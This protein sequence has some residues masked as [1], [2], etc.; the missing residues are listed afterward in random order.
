MVHLRF[1]PVARLMAVFVTVAAL[2]V[3]CGSDVSGK[4]LAQGEGSRTE[5]STP[6]APS[7]QGA[8]SGGDTSA[9]SP[10]EI[11]VG[12]AAPTRTPTAQSSLS[13]LPARPNAAQA[14]TPGP[15][16]GTTKGE[17]RAGGQTPSVPDSPSKPTPPGSGAAPVPAPAAPGGPETLIK[18]GSIGT[19]TGPIG[20]AI[21]GNFQGA[22]AWVAD[23]N[24]RGGLNGHPVQVI[25]GDDGGDPARS[26]SLVK[27][28]VEQDRV[29]GFFPI[30][31]PVTG[32]AISPYL[33]EKK[34]PAL[35]S[36][37]CSETT[38]TSPM[39]FPVGHGSTVGNVW[40][41]VMPLLTASDKRNVGLFYCR[42]VKVCTDISNGI[43]E[44]A[45][46]MGIKLVYKAQM[47]LAQPDFTAEVL[48]ARNAGADAIVI[49][50]E[51]ASAIRI[52]R[53]ARR[54][55]YN[56][57]F[58]SQYNPHDETFLK[59]GGSDVEGF[60]LEARTAPWSTSPLMAD[61]RAALPKYVP[62]ALFSDHTATS[63]V[64]GKLLEKIATRFPATV[65]S[66]DVLEGLYSLRG[67]TLGGLLPPITYKRD[68]GHVDTNQCGIPMTVKN[69][70][71][72]TL[73]GEVFSC[74]RWWK[75]AGA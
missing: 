11:P 12:A 13:P 26:L 34:I 24:S 1:G 10:A 56:P 2:G 31:A 63:W 17:N 70:K 66:N 57:L 59:N 73:N 69:G 32:Q 51:N 58:S 67:E 38:D 15:Q 8:P 19:N 50:M 61:L 75:P 25:F 28:M 5:A 40:A 68:Q 23:V 71:F 20:Q 18:L 62:G 35:E 9:S 6:D 74:A 33:E 43:T 29:V 72:V 55:G 4:R 47:S 30:Y 7:T 42:E 37:S 52:V 48:A 65:T 49:I 3:G 16:A 45:G 54:Q 14:A 21:I 41:H 44:K 46:V 64:A 53:S 36:C 27:K 39:M 60:L 22:K